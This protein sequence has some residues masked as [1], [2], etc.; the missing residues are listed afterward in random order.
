MHFLL[1]RIFK[2]RIKLYNYTNFLLHYYYYYL[3]IIIIVVFLVGTRYVQCSFVKVVRTQRASCRGPLQ[4]V[5]VCAA[6][7]FVLSQGEFVSRQEVPA[8][9]RAPKALHVIYFFPS[10]HHQVTAA[11]ARVTLCTF[12]T[13]QP[14]KKQEIAHEIKE[15]PS[16]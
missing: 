10:S 1:K 6:Q 3:I 5:V 2:Y 7:Q 13:K 9:H 4:Q 11:E 12:D 8:A 14:G 16:K 15:R